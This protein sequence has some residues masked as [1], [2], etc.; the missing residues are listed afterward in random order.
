MEDSPQ[1]NHDIESERNDADGETQINDG[2][3]LSTSS[4]NGTRQTVEV[5]HSPDYVVSQ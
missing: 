3:N 1:C 2:G 5:D 4:L